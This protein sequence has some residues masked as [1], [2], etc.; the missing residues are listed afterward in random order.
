MKDEYIIINRTTLEKRIEELEK[1]I[2]FYSNEA[3]KI[4]ANQCLGAA[5]TLK[6]IL[7]QSTPLIPVIEKAFVSGFNEGLL[8]DEELKVTIKDYIANLKLDV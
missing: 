1:D 7:T 2:K 3:K 4:E 8:T 6:Q 5:D